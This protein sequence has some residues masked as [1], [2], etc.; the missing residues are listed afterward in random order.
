MGCCAST[1][2]E[3]GTIADAEVT[4]AERGASRTEEVKITLNIAE[5][6]AVKAK[7]GVRAHTAE[8]SPRAEERAR[9]RGPH[10]VSP[11][12]PPLAHPGSPGNLCAE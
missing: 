10:G 3:V 1:E 9:A 8:F 4:A 6:D 7:P 2:E 5:S 11:P 12:S